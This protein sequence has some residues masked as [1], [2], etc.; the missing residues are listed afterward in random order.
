MVLG[1]LGLWGFRGHPPLQGISAVF[2]F[3]IALFISAGVRVC[4]QWNR[5]AVLRL[6]NYQ[7]MKG[8][9]FFW[10]MPIRDAT[11]YV[12]DL[13]LVTYDVPKQE[14]LTKDN[15][16][17]TVDAIVYYKVADPEAAVLRIEDFNRATQLGAQTLLRDLIGKAHLDALLSEREELSGKLRENLDKMTG[18]WGIKVQDV[19]LKEVV[20]GKNL[21]DAIAREPAAER[22]KRARLK[23]AEAEL[24]A[25]HTI[26]EAAQIYEKDPVALQLRAMNMLY[27]M[28]MEGTTTVVFVP[29]ET[30]QG[31][32]MPLGVY[33]IMDGVNMPMMPRTGGGLTA[34]QPPALPTEGGE[35][36]GTGSADASA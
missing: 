14:S 5:M 30:R 26:F 20:I 34:P 11:P 12:V 33:G 10:I 25:A 7:G 21:Q 17:V 3:L 4:D 28:C 9:G 29:T 13:R 8:P 22:E 32:P 35:A 31:M 1:G 19:E 2:A 15:I 18:D 6:G 36:A 27:E 24:L 23:L 16:P